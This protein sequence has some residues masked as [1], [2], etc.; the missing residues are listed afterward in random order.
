MTPVDLLSQLE[1]AKFLRLFLY[2]ANL[3]DNN[4]VPDNLCLPPV[5]LDL[6]DAEL[7]V[8]TVGKASALRSWAT[9]W[10][11]QIE[12]IPSCLW[13]KNVFDQ[14]FEARL[15]AVFRNLKLKSDPLQFLHGGFND[16]V[17]RPLQYPLALDLDYNIFTNVCCDIDDDAMSRFSDKAHAMFS[18]MLDIPLERHPRFGLGTPE[19]ALNANPAAVEKF[20]LDL[21]SMPSSYYFLAREGRIGG[22]A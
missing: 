22:A 18:E 15:R 9:S 14:Y 20:I 8:R 1:E 3:R 6:A 17:E 4:L 11:F 21:L 12:H 5:P 19:S 16:D 10:V 7:I 13:N 2:L